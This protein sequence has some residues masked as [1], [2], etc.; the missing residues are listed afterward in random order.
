MSER[1]LTGREYAALLSLFAQVSH[2]ETLLPQLEKRIKTI[3]GLWEKLMDA[4]AVTEEALAELPKTIPTNKLRHVMADIKNAKIYIRI[5]PPGCVPSMDMSG[6]SY[7]PTKTLNELLC[8]VMDHDCI[9][10]DKSPTEARKCPARMMIE[11]ALPHEVTAKDAAHC[12]YSDMSLGF[13]GGEE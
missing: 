3:P 6:F 2:F 9:M 5:E 1:Y 11:N 4:Q 7:I 10:C 13:T 12:R 8:Y